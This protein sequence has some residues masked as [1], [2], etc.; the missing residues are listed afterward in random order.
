MWDKEEESEPTE[1]GQP[2]MDL[3]SKILLSVDHVPGTVPDTGV[4]ETWA[5]LC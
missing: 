2:G 5:L 4:K 3:V 1:G